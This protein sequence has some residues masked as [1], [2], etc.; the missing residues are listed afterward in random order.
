MIII[1]YLSSELDLLPIGMVVMITVGIYIVNYTALSTG[2]RT[3]SAL[4]DAI[5]FIKIEFLRSV[6]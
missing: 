1:S 4:F 2:L 6:F 3:N 5:I